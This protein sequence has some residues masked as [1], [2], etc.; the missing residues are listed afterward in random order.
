[1]KGIQAMSGAA[2]EVQKDG[3]GAPTRTVTVTGLPANVLMACGMLTAVI[4]Q[5]GRTGGGSHSAGGRSSGPR[6]E[7]R[8]P[9]DASKLGWVLGPK[10]ATIK[11]MRSLTGAKIDVLEEVSEATGRRSG[12]VVLCGSET[13]VEEA[14]GAVAGLLGGGDESRAYAA[15]LVKAAE[16]RAAWDEAQAAAALPPPPLAAAADS[17]AAPLAS[18]WERRTAKHPDG[19]EVVY[20]YHSASGAFSWGQ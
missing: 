14:R 11:A 15:S 4:D 10:G 3:D 8:L 12:V 13:E 7:L 6:K 17:A 1:M 9:C 18:A 16:E 20:F 5:A 19:K 2:V